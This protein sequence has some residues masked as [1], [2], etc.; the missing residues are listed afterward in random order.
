MS[1]ECCKHGHVAYLNSDHT[2]DKQF[3]I[4]NFGMDSVVERR[5]EIHPYNPNLKISV[6]YVKNTKETLKLCSCECHLKG[7]GIYV[8]H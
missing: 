2:V 6:I 7:V 4:E 5:T 3:I 1:N 8:L